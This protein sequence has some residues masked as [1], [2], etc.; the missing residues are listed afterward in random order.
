GDH[1]P[2]VK[3]HLVSRVSKPNPGRAVI[4]QITLNWH[5]LVIKDN[6]H[7]H[8]LQPLQ[9]SPWIPLVKI[10]NAGGEDRAAT[11]LERG[12]AARALERERKCLAELQRLLIASGNLDVA[13]LID[14]LD[15]LVSR[16][17]LSHVVIEIA[18]GDDRHRTISLEVVRLLHLARDER[19][20]RH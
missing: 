15:Q 6:L 18:V 7:T 11:E 3:R 14:V 1:L 13:E 20:P 17:E 16:R 2:A 9:V 4:C 19:G 10:L 5:H 12:E 8:F